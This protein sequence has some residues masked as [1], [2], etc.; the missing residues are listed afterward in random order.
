MTVSRIKPALARA[1]LLGCVALSGFTLPGAVPAQTVGPPVRLGPPVPLTSPTLPGGQAP[2]TPSPSRQQTPA[3][4]A[5]E[6]SSR[7]PRPVPA[8]PEG[9]AAPVSPVA[10]PL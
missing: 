1:A 6:P 10:R 7:L 2:E 4:G 5:P 9:F 8:Q 3:A